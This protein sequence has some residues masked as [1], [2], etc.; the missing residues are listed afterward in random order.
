MR[1]LSTKFFFGITGI[2]VL[3]LAGHPVT[4]FQ[5][6]RSVIIDTSRLGM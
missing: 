1:R 2:L 6:S 5:G 4:Q 3:I